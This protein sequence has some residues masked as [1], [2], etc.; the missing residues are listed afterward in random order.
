[1]DKKYGYKIVL[2]FVIPYLIVLFVAFLSIGMLVTNFVSGFK[3]NLMETNYSM[4]KQTKDMTDK[5]IYEVEMTAN[6]LALNNR[7][8]SLLYSEAEVDDKYRYKL[9]EIT[10][11]LVSY[12]SRSEIIETF[13]IYL[14]NSK[15]VITPDTV[16]TIESFCKY[17]LAMDSVVDYDKIMEFM[18]SDNNDKYFK[19]VYIIP[20]TSNPYN[21]VGMKSIVYIK[22]IPLSARLEP[23]GFI[24]MVINENEL[25][26]ILLTNIS[27]EEERMCYIVDGENEVI[28]KAGNGKDCFDKINLSKVSEGYY[29][30]KIEGKPYFVSVSSSEYNDWKYV[31][32]APSK[33][34]EKAVKD[35]EFLALIIMGF[36]FIIGIMISILLALRSSKPLRSMIK[37]INTMGVDGENE[38]N[39][40]TSP[41]EYLEDAM[42][43][44]VNKNE[45]FN[46]LMDKQI[47]LMYVTFFDR[48]FKGHF[49]NAKEILPFASYV[50]VDIEGKL[51]SVVIT[52]MYEYKSIED[53]KA[54]AELGMSKVILKKVISQQLGQVGYVYDVDENNMAILFVFKENVE[55]VFK[56]NIQQKLVEIYDILHKEYN[57]SVFFGIGDIYDDVMNV[58][59]SY[60]EAMQ[61]VESRFVKKEQV[62][63]WFSDIPQQ[64]E[65]YYFP[66]E[67]KQ[68]LI[69]LTKAGELE[70]LEELLQNLSEEN[71]EKR[72]ISQEMCRQL[73]YEIRGTL[74]QFLLQN[75]DEKNMQDTLSEI[76]KMKSL[77]TMWN[78]ICEYFKKNCI[79]IDKQKK[80]HNIELKEQIIEYINKVYVSPNLS[81]YDVAA[82]FGLTE[83]YLSHFFKEQTGE[84]FSTYLE[85]LRIEEACKLLNDKTLTIQEISEKVGYNSVY[86]FRRA[87][88]RVKG[89]SPSGLRE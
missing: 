17:Y 32:L 85:N 80:S 29:E 82:K 79:K 87:F 8:N 68:R 2:S 31:M 65:A 20:H 50:R 24:M 55:D 81:R 70:S 74:I 16:H 71:F 38:K 46:E 6:Q 53:E 66:V 22:N 12:N 48:L 23:L 57:M 7:I 60:Q 42:V 51:Y 37:K 5:W 19:D 67:L 76:D 47:P 75:S 45:D 72:H 26:E 15:Y 62:Y 43:K 61:V 78:C 28:L 54:I 77:D 84:N 10:K 88:K 73:N 30:E 11:D 59:V 56:E 25:K 44:L 18:K 63:T 21:Y 1:M 86:S 83:G 52:R 49:N 40:E 34:I 14:D 36:M 35:F 89:V 13:F 27:D 4:L 58:S 33:D 41:Y 69:N 64:S 39:F 9:Y 3:N